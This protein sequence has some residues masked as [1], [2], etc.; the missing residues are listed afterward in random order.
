[1][2][3]WRS[4]TQTVIL[5]LLCVL[6]LGFAY[7]ALTLG[8]ASIFSDPANLGRLFSFSSRFSNASVALH[9]IAGGIITVLCPLQI[10]PAI[11]KKAP[12]LHRR[13]GY[14]ILICALVT[15]FGGFGYMIHRGTIG[16]PLMTVGFSLYGALMGVSVIQT[17][18]YAR[19]K[20]F[21]R[22]RRWALRL[23]LLAI[24]S[25]LYRVHY[26]IW[27]ATTGGLGSTRAFDG[28]FDQ[29][30]V[31][32]FYLPYLVCLELYFRMFEGRRFRTGTTG[33]AK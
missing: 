28:V 5:T 21:H 4:I 16:G 10:V 23:F 6:T 8:G 1:M 30:Q 22:H 2:F 27:Y 20:D 31:F 25:W 17:L 14:T 24:G 26:G 11:R 9:M 19:A 13:M 7:H 32:A 12:G 3:N 18:R 29:I 33:A 15:M